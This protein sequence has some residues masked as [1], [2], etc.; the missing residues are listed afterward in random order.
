MAKRTAL[1]HMTPGIDHLALDVEKSQFYEWMCCSPENLPKDQLTIAELLLYVANPLNLHEDLRE[2]EY[3]DFAVE[4]DAKILQGLRALER[5]RDILRPLTPHAPVLT[6]VSDPAYR[7]RMFRFGANG[8]PS[9]DA[10]VKMDVP[11]DLLDHLMRQ[12]IS[13]GTFKKDI[14]E[15]FRRDKR[16]ERPSNETEE[17]AMKVAVRLMDWRT[18]G[19]KRSRD[20]RKY[21]SPLTLSQLS[22]LE[23]YTFQGKHGTVGF[24]TTRVKRMHRVFAKLAARAASALTTYRQKPLYILHD[25]CRA[26]ILPDDFFGLRFIAD[27]GGLGNRPHEKVANQVYGLL[28]RIIT[29]RAPDGFRESHFIVPEGIHHTKFDTE[30]ADNEGRITPVEVKVYAHIA[31]YFYDDFFGAHSRAHYDLI[32]EIDKIYRKRHLAA[33]KPP[34]RK[35]LDRITQS[36]AHTIM[37][38]RLN[39][40]LE[41]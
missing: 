34:T 8:D 5:V 39:R 29:S 11:Y 12:V 17:M 15:Y 6:G 27:S 14:V 31:D 1:Q 21:Y 38:Y 10:I 30:V 2:D 33:I 25:D 16:G 9:L 13:T 32:T 22:D 7:R 23:V 3:R 28:K 35:A 36:E 4:L 40:F 41:M 19:G 18:Y 20:A 37:H 24:E 26:H